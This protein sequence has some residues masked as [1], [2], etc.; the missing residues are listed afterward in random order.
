MFVECVR[1]DATRTVKPMHR[2]AP[3]NV[4]YHPTFCERC[5]TQL[6]VVDTDEVYHFLNVVASTSLK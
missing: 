5:D 1:V 6:G 3:D 2:D 4:R